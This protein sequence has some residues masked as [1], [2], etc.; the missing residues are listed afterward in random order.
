MSVP[1][2]VEKARKAREKKALYGTDVDLESYESE[3]REH[4]TVEKAEEL[5]SE[6]KKA[7]LD[8]GV[9]LDAEASGAYVQM[10]QTPVVAKS[11]YEGVEIGED[12]AGLDRLAEA[13][14]VGKQQPRRAARARQ[15]GLELV[16]EQVDAG[17]RDASQI[18][19]AVIAGQQRAQAEHPPAPSDRARPGHVFGRLQSVERSEQ[20]PADPEIRRRG[21]DETA[22]AALAVV[23]DLDDAPPA[24]PRVDQR[25][26]AGCLRFLRHRFAPLLQRLP[27]ITE[28]TSVD[29]FAPLSAQGSGLKAQASKTRRK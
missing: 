27:L 18:V 7:A 24:A 29:I 11:L 1:S 28:L 4:G 3:A 5:P 21:A 22:R 20:R 8:V 17:R 6:V 12:D 10:D 15:G 23:D 14:L 16:V 9:K 25:A 19:R 2:I 13:D 26:G